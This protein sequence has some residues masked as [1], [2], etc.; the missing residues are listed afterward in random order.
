MDDD[1]T[2]RTRGSLDVGQLPDAGGADRRRAR[3]LHRALEKE[4]GTVHLVVTDNR[5]RMLT[6]K[7]AGEHLEIRLHHMFLSCDEEIVDAIVRLADGD[8]SAR[9]RI[10]SYVSSNR[11]K[12]QFEP[13]EEELTH[14]GE[15]FHLQELLETARSRLE[16]SELDDISISWG[17]DGRGEKSIRFGSFDFD[18]RLIRIH[19]ALDQEWVPEF[20]VEFIVYHEL[21][22]ALHPPR[23]GDERRRVHTDEFE[24]REREHP[25]YEDALEWESA[26]IDRLLDR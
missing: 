8:D 14:R 20:F 6:T 10:Q 12:I 16:E 19:P 17:R 21:L 9:E 5:R 3:R 18:Q 25:R 4:L 23:E 15:H 1:A 11:D 7:S 22:H 13:S 26:N 24:R 2:G